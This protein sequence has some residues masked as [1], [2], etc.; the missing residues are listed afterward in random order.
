[1]SDSGNGTIDNDWEEGNKMNGAATGG[2]A[3]A[4]AAKN[5]EVSYSSSASSASSSSSMD[6]LTAMALEREVKEQ[7]EKKVSEDLDEKSSDEEEEEEAA[8][9]KESLKNGQGCQRH[10]EGYL[11]WGKVKGYSYWPGII[12]VDPED[13]MTVTG[14]DENKSKKYHVHFLGYENQRAWVPD[15][16]IL[17]FRGAESYRLLAAG[18]KG[19]RK[20]DFYPPSK[21]QR[22]MFDKGLELAEHSL[23]LPP[24]KRLEML[25][26][27]YV[28]IEPK[29]K[30]AR[31]RTKAAKKAQP[32]K[33]TATNEG[34][35]DADE[36]KARSKKRKRRRS[37]RKPSDV[38][39]ISPA[40]PR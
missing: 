21:K 24:S 19:P 16:A 9:L 22:E 25:G 2:T 18:A 33:Q 6:R 35:G 15:R 5:D 10:E 11:L 14:G 31:V 38:E 1:M 30:A 8:S 23:T 40:T 39:N 13:G 37:D 3:A 34:D 17:E 26:Y 7:N 20:K 12:T 29:P 4:A 32:E 36:S 27:V 28:L